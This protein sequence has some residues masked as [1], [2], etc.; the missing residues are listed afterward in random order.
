MTRLLEQ[1]FS[2][3]AQLPEDEQNAFAAFLLEELRSEE[4][5]NR[6]F[7]RSGDAL[8]KL[9]AEALGEYRTGKT[10]PLDPDRL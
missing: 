5:W 1:A 9:A 8:A 7:A 10:K 6:S 4:R 2:E 3:A